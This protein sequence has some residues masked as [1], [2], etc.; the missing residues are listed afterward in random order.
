MVMEIHG[1]LSDA[2]SVEFR[3][4]QEASRLPSPERSPMSPLKCWEPS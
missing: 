4:A 3:M 1:F 2:V